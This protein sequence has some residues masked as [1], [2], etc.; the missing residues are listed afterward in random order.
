ML[1]SWTS[2]I[3]EGSVNQLIKTIDGTSVFVEEST[4]VYISVMLL[5]HRE[6]GM[7]QS[8]WT[9]GCGRDYTR[10]RDFDCFWIGCGPQ[11]CLLKT[12]D[13]G[14]F[15]N[16]C[17]GTCMNDV[18]STSA[19]LYVVTAHKLTSRGDILP[20]FNTRIESQIIGG[21]SIPSLHLETCFITG[22]NIWRRVWLAS[23]GITIFQ[24][25][26]N[27]NHCQKWGCIVVRYGRYKERRSKAESRYAHSKYVLVDL[28]DMS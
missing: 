18:N 22:Y 25:E 6:T 15:V 8:L 20:V 12:E 19:S 11:K 13:P 7:A 21:T 10:Q 5:I 27:L 26:R 3:A 17:T 23:L 1:C 9:Q 2:E 14:R 16:W 28:T 4:K 24:A